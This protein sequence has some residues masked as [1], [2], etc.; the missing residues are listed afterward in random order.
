[1]LSLPADLTKNRSLEDLVSFLDECRQDSRRQKK[2]IL[3]SISVQVHS[4]DPLA[5]LESIFEANH[6]HFYV[7]RPNENMALAGAEAIVSFTASGENRFKEC[8][9]FI[10]TTL[11]NAVAV[12]DLNSA[13]SGPHF[14]T[15]FSFL[16]TCEKDEPFASATIFV[17]RWQVGVKDGITVAVANLCVD[18]S[19]DVV[20]Q[21]E[22]L[23]K[24]HAKFGSFDYSSPDFKNE[25]PQHI[26]VSE[27]I[28]KDVFVDSV[29]Q[30]LNQINQGLFKK[31]VLA[32]AKDFVSVQ[33]FHPLRILSGLRQRFNDCYSFS[34]AN[35]LGQSFIGASP[36]RLVKCDNTKITTEALAGS[37]KRGAS[38]SE[39]A[40]FA[41]S[42]L[43]DDKELSEHAL[44]AES[45]RTYL[46]NLGL[47]VV[48]PARPSI[49]RYA[50]VQHLHTPIEAERILS[51]SIFD[52]LQSLHP[53]PAVGGLPREVTVPKIRSLEGFS[54]GL[55]TGALGFVNAQGDGEFFV[56]L[57][58]ALID[59]Q[60]ARLYA[61]AGI[62]AGSIAEREYDEIE[63]KFKAM[64]EAILS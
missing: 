54:R 10:D 27:V 57:R 49:H 44:V 40:F 58:S 46:S 2:S 3:V 22:R 15:T 8:Q 36:E 47:H 32:R 34:V 52:I 59:G 48:M 14:F 4:L 43:K 19:C 9:H 6:Q 37:T 20:F 1:M 18:E 39:D 13:F 51:V 63:L 28:S 38:A 23:F 62:V 42:L 53:T 35:G 21:A 41:S 5:V 16:N 61:G 45:I 50:N 12:G 31:I 11:E 17:P 24:A 64:H 26:N 60:N 33:P 25:R 29:K 55:Y 56:G 7:E 30:S